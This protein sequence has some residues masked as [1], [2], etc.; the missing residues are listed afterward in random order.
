MALSFLGVSEEKQA[1]REIRTGNVWLLEIFDN[2]IYAAKFFRRENK[3]IKMGGIFMKLYK[4]WL[5]VEEYDTEKDSYKDIVDSGEVEPVPLGWFTNKKEAVGCMES[6]E[7]TQGMSPTGIETLI[8]K[9]R[10]KGK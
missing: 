3:L 2:L 6:L 4:V 5:E 10:R 8:R 9:R 1:L 7:Y